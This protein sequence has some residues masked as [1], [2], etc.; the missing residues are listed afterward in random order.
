MKIKM[1]GMLGLGLAM[2]SGL[3]AQESKGFDIGASL[4]VPTDSLKVITNKGPLAGFG[5]EAGYTGH[6]PGSTVPF[7]SGIAVNSFAGEEH[8]LPIGLAANGTLL[9]TFKSK[10]SLTHFQIFGDVH[11]A[12]GFDKLNLAL[13]LSLN[14]WQ[15]KNEV[16]AAYETDEFKN[17]THAVKGLKMGARIGLEYA[18]TQ[19]WQASAMLQAVEFGTDRLQ[20]KGYNPA[21]IQFGV[22]YTF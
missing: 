3:G 17:G 12:T 6:V 10:T 9:G 19:K 20:T 7:R 15:A 21:W 2:A 14:K 16:P 8:D 11:V 18:F 5:I 1:F 22:R 13:G 4:S